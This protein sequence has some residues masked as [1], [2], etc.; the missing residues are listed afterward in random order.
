MTSP[1]RELSPSEQLAAHIDLRLE[2]TYAALELIIMAT[3]AELEKMQADQQAAFTDFADDVMAKL[4]EL[5]AKLDAALANDSA[6]AAQLAE[7]KALTDDVLAKGSAFT[8]A[9]KAADAPFDRPMTPEE[10]VA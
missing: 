2:Q 5:N 4:S 8:D 6:D 10:P 3:K 9:V 1:L 7:F